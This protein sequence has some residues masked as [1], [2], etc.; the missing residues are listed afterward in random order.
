MNIL[1]HGY[2]SNKDEGLLIG[3][4]IADFVKG[5]PA[6]ARHGLAPP[7]IAGIRLHR[8]ID[9]FTDTHP[10]VEAVRELLRPRCHKYAGVAVDM[11]FDHFL[12]VNFQALT[13]EHLT[14][15]VADFY[16]TIRLNIDR[17]PTEA[18]RMAG[19]M[20]RQDWLIHYQTTA[21]IDRSLQGLAQR[22]LFRSG[23]DTVIE[24]FARY[25]EPISNH[26]AYF[27]PALVAHGQQVRASLP[28]NNS[29]T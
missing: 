5:D 26:F 17:L 25:Y 13:G 11:F 20:I 28:P 2:L 8:S 22:T 4:F 9:L 14:D 18:A 29:T 12:A 24:D 15:F 3:N 7:E 10:A 1:A 19:Y 16:Q 23:L 27:W 6:A 21:G